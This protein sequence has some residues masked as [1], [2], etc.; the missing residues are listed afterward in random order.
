MSGISTIKTT[1]VFTRKKI[2]SF[3]FVILIGLAAL[4]LSISSTQATVILN[5]DGSGQLTGAQNVDLGSLGFFN[6]EFVDGT[7]IALFD[8]C[9]QVADFDFTNEADALLAAQA[10]LDQVLVDDFPLLGLFVFTKV[11]LP[12][13]PSPTRSR[14]R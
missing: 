3:A 9:N 2:K 8:G 10:L 5:V 13:A 7:C 4:G 14:A 11:D 12:F 6:V 1:P